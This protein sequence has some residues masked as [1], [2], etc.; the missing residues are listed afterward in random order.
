L[1]AIHRKERK[2]GGMRFKECIQNVK[3]NKE[4]HVLPS[5]FLKARVTHK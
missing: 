2:G 3:G 1:K 5:Q 4:K